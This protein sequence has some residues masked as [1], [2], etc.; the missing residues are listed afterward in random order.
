MKVLS[1]SRGSRNFR[2]QVPATV[3]VESWPGNFC[4]YSYSRVLKAWS[5]G[6]LTV[7]GHVRSD[8]HPLW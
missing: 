7:A 6:G 8:K 2:V 3:T 5:C 4:Q 1:V